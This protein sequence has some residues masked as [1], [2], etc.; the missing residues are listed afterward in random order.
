MSFF[1]AVLPL[2]LDTETRIIFLIFDLGFDGEEFVILIGHGYLRPFGV[3]SDL[4]PSV[5]L[6]EGVFSSLL[7]FWIPRLY[8]CTLCFIPIANIVP[9][10]S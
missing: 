9:E 3:S 1:K 8:N 4:T 7:T 5:F 6:S 2:F 10:I